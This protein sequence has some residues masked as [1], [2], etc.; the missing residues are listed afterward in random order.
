MAAAKE[1]SGVS[2]NCILMTPERVFVEGYSHTCGIESDLDLRLRP[3][4]GNTGTPLKPG[5]MHA[6]PAIS[7]QNGR[8]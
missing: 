2:V 8:E 3:R 4:G 6:T 5:Q 7:S 1:M